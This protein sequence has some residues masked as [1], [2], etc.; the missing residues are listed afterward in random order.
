[1]NARERPQL[2]VLASGGA[3]TLREIVRAI[4]ANRHRGIDPGFDIGLVVSDHPE[5]T[6]PTVERLNQEFGL[7]I[8]MEVV[9]RKLYPNGPAARGITDEESE[10]ICKLFEEGGFDAIAC[11]GFMR[12]LRGLL[13]DK[14]GWQPGMSPFEAKIINTHPGKLPETADTHGAGASQ[15]AIDLKLPFTAHTLHV[16]STGVDEG[17]VLYET[18]VPIL[19]GDNAEQVFERVQIAEKAVL[20]LAISAFL[21]KR[22]CC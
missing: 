17:E 12:I 2:M 3:S 13:I 7:D 14:Y 16:V 9:N 1:M 19:P 5:E 11:L 4:E 21:K 10:V 20:P 18:P 15:K 6:F 8:R 22:G